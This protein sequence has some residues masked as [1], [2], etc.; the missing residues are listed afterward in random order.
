MKP[1][2]TVL[3]LS[4]AISAPAFADDQ[5]FYGHIDYWLYM[6]SNSPKDSSI[7]GIRIGGGYHFNP[8]VGVEG[9]LSTID[10]FQTKSSPCTNIFGTCPQDSL[11][12]SSYQY[13][14]VGTLPNGLFVKLGR[15]TTTFD[16]SY[17]YTPCTFGFCS[18]TVTGSG[19]ATKTNPMFG[20]GWQSDVNQHSY[21]RV[22]YENF[23][24]I[25]LTTNYNNQPSTTSDIGIEVI[26]VGIVYNF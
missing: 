23:G 9:G 26:S 8:Y 11:S 3:T 7:N 2:A 4:A 18:P 17:S 10:I 19:S 12:A 6:F 22:Q 25:K 21:W 16:Y 20:I 24:T 5:G 15:A 14:F 1:I 13:S